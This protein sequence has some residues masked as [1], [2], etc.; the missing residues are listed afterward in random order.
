MCVD[1]NAPMLKRTLFSS[2]L[3]PSGGALGAPGGGRLMPAAAAGILWLLAALVTA[4]WLLQVWGRESLVPVA[5]MAGNPLQADVG[6]VAR[7]LGAQ[8][9]APA[10]AP[11]APPVSSRFKLMGLVGQ[12]GQRGAALIGV[13]AQPPRPVTVGAVVDGDLRLLLVGQRMVRL[14]VRSDDPAAFELSLP[15]LKE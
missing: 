9:E 8:P 11:V 12:P 2:P 7:A 4:Y 13:D 5:A 3:R 14:G 1:H 6:A 15:E 10:S